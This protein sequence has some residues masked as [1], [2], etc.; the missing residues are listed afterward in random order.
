M[1]LQKPSQTTAS[2]GCGGIFSWACLT[3]LTDEHRA[4]PPRQVQERLRDML[5]AGCVRP[6]E[7]SRRLGCPGSRDA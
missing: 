5:R 4:Q 3:L 7:S 2:A 1:L 6:D